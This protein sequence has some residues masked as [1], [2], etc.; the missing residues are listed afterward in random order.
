MVRTRGGRDLSCGGGGGGG[1]AEATPG[2]VPQP[3][4]IESLVSTFLVTLTVVGLAIVG[5]MAI[6]VR[7]PDQPATLRTHR[8]RAQR[9]PR[10]PTRPAPPPVPAVTPTPPPAP[11]P[12]PAVFAQDGVGFTDTWVRTA[13][14]PSVWLRV[15]SGVVLTVLL[16]VVGALVAI[17]IAGVVV[18]V[19][20]AL[21]SAVS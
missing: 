19:A 10:T 17:S 9:A 12:A 21:R 4:T 6:A 1:D 15:R 5:A 18:L 13:S 16:A 3:G 14:G 7:D 2:G 11:A 8:P 20:L